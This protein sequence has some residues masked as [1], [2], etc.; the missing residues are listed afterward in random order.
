MTLM[1]YVDCIN[2]LSVS[3]RVSVGLDNSLAS[4]GHAVNQGL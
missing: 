1:F 4:S 2:V 3:C